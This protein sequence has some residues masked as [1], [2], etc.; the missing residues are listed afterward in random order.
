MHPVPA[1]STL[2]LADVELR[3]LRIVTQMGIDLMRVDSPAGSPIG[4]RRFILVDSRGVHDLRT[5]PNGGRPGPGTD[6]AGTL[7]DLQQPGGPLGP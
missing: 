6:C 2:Q 4:P 5:V 1:C 3:R 7:L